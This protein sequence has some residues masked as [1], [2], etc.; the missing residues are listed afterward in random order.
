MAEPKVNRLSS[1]RSGTCVESSRESRSNGR[2]RQP[3]GFPKIV[4]VVP[5]KGRPIQLANAVCSIDKQTLPPD[6]TIVVGER[7]ADLASLRSRAVSSPYHFPTVFLLNNR[8]ANLSGAANS[9]ILQVLERKF[10]PERSYLAFLDDD[11]WWAPEYLESCVSLAH[12]QNLDWVIAGITRHESQ[13]SR[14]TNL[15]VPQN[16]TALAFLRTNPHLQGS[17]LFVRLSTLLK[18]GCFDENLQSTTDRDLGIRLLSLGDTKVGFVRRHLAHH[19]A[20]GENRLSTFGSPQKR[21]GLI[22]FYQKYVPIMSTED[23]AAFVR[24]ART[25]FGCPASDFS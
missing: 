12:I 7:E 14:G 4:A 13:A 24:R 15:A 16:L 5:T 22:T 17:N 25:V 18:A 6:L 19:K 23:R 11:D 3:D 10:V 20:Y 1:H 9:A 8:T 2:L 21:A